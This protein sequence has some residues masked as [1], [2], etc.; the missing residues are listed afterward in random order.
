VADE[1][2][3]KLPDELWSILRGVRRVKAYAKG[4]ALFCA[5]EPPKGVYLI[6]R[7]AVR[8]HLPSPGP[9]HHFDQTAGAGAILALSETMTGEDHKFTAEAAENTEAWFVERQDFLRLL[10]HNQLLCLQIVHLLSEDLHLLYH[11]VQASNR[12]V[13]MSA[14]RASK[15]GST[16]SSI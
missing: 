6:E 5:T 16:G 7:G 3:N 15:K 13:P 9:R 10:R 14:K 4:A 1:A 8:I 2:P 11:M 12:P